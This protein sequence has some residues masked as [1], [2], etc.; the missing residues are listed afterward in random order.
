MN[1]SSVARVTSSVNVGHWLLVASVSVILIL[2]LEA[3]IECVTRFTGC[4][5]KDFDLNQV[6][7]SLRVTHIFGGQY[8][9]SPGA[10][11]ESWKVTLLGLAPKSCDLDGA[12]IFTVME[13][14][15]CVITGVHRP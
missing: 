3:V 7:L 4:S 13:S 9:E 15:S 11:S 14:I 2:E 6:T 10:N 8:I 12:L 5:C 1:L